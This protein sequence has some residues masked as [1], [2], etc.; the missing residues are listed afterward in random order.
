MSSRRRARTDQPKSQIPDWVWG[1]GLGII[2]LIFV[3]AFF[4]FSQL[5][6]ATADACDKALPPLGSLSTI[7]AA[8]FAQ[9]DVSLGHVIDLLDQG[10]LNA[11]GTIFYG[12]VHSFTH[13]VD[14]GIRA[15]DETVAKTLCKAVYKLE[16]DLL[17]AT[18]HATTDQLSADTTAVRNALR[19]G[20]EVL[21]FPRPTG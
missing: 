10:D 9:E 4:L 14:P 11:A 8:A 21:G 17:V 16:N 7:D 19:D 13:N 12:P 15:K 20:A 3:S 5:G 18:S 6:G 1:A 2:V